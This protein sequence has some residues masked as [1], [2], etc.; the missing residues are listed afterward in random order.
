[1]LSWESSSSRDVFG[2]EED[3]IL[4]LYD[5]FHIIHL[6]YALSATDICGFF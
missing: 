6:L 5:S 4:L 2:G 3:A 1:M